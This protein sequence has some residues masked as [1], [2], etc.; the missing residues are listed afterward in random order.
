M[1]RD[2]LDCVGRR[3]HRRPQ[4]DGAD[5]DVGDDGEEDDSGRD[6]TVNVHED[7]PHRQC[8]RAGTVVGVG[9]LRLV[10]DWPPPR[11]VDRLYPPH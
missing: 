6:Q 2:T 9:K 5:Q 10:A 8:F 4:Q 3:A 1:R 11:A 7:R